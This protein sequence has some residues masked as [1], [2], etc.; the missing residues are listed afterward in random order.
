M[1][2][3]RA[4]SVY[5]GSEGRRVSAIERG[6]DDGCYLGAA[7]KAADRPPVLDGDQ[8]VLLRAN[9]NTYEALLR[10]AGDAAGPRLTYDGETLEVMSPSADHE[11]VNRLFEILVQ[12]FSDERGIRIQ[13]VGSTTLKVEPR[14]G[15]PD[16]AFYVRNIAAI[17]GKRRIDPSV[18]PVPDIVLEVDL[19]R[20]R[21]NKAANYRAIGIDEFWR[22][23]GS[24]LRAYSLRTSGDQE[25]FDS[26]WLPGFAVADVERLLSLRHTTDQFDIRAQWRAMLRSR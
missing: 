14:G 16:S 20:T 25:I 2:A 9:W 22:Y 26:V 12:T 6:A 4:A 24:R 19:S 15:E 23:D 8:V 1:I 10:D 3:E 13:S 5:G 18:D 21:I 17:L 11:S 7:M